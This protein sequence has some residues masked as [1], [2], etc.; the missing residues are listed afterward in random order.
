MAMDSI[1]H[2]NL[3]CDAIDSRQIT[4]LFGKLTLI[5]VQ[6]NSDSQQCLMISQTVATA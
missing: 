2:V 5:L 3:T 1:Q 6:Q 4:G